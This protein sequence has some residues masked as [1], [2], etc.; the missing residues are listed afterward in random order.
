MDDRSITRV[1]NCAW[2]FGTRYGIAYIEDSGLASELL[3]MQGIVVSKP[4]AGAM[5]T[6]YS[7][8]GKAFAW[9]VRFGIDHWDRV[10]RKIGLPA[11]HRTTKT[12]HKVSARQAA[13]GNAVAKRV[14]KTAKAVSPT[15]ARQRKD[16][17][18][19]KGRSSPRK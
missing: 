10:A 5:A 13:A 6:Y 9:Q 16:K 8:K 1:E 18:S 2:R 3:K 7:P 17:R 11:D 15:A 12:E 14:P 19:P 4:S